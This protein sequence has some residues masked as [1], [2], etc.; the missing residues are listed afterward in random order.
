M[1]N[2]RREIHPPQEKDD[3]ESIKEDDSAE[4]E[5][6]KS[7]ADGEESVAE[8]DLKQ[9]IDGGEGKDEIVIGDDGNWKRAKKRDEEDEEGKHKLIEPH[10]I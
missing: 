3:D 1:Q 9:R 5:K 10:T 8:D 2:N 4:V 7:I 6:D